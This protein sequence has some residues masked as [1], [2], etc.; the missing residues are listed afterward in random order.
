M[1]DAYLED[2]E[3]LRD[4]QLV[5]LRYEDLVTDPKA[6]LSALYEKLD[7]G[8]FSRVE[9]ALDAHLHEVRAYRKNR[10]SMD[11]ETSELIRREWARYFDEFGYE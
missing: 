3:L 8:D 5:E 2:R 10:H 4:N 9:P 6:R 11:D 1:Y 7:L